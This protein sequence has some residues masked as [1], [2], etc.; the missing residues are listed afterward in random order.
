MHKDTEYD[1]MTFKEV[2]DRLACNLRPSNHFMQVDM[3]L[4]SRI[5]VAQENSIHYLISKEK[6]IGLIYP[7]MSMQKKIYH[8]IV[9]LRKTF[10]DQ[11]FL[12]KFKTI[13]DLKSKLH[14]LLNRDFLLQ[15][16]SCGNSS[17]VKNT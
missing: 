11:V 4:N 5:Q 14:S 9:G 13:E 16:R 10:L 12:E 6:L 3:L 8:I 15:K 17:Q 1:S 7:E 2:T